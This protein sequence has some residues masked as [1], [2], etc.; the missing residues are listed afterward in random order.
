[1]AR[2][3]GV[4]IPDNKQVAFSLVYIYGIGKTLANK[5]IESAGIDKNKLVKDLDDSE[6]VKILSIIESDYAVERDLRREIKSNVQR[7]IDIN[8]YRGNRHRKGLPVRGQRTKT[9]SRTRRTGPRQTAA[10]KR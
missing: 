1:M 9:N 10:G 2:I 8:S 5:I 6:L 7:L 3:A 4:E